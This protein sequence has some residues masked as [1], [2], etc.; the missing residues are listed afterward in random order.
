MRTKY[1]D[2]SHHF[3]RDIVEDKYTVIK[4]IRSKENPEKIITNNCFGW[5][6]QIHEI[7]HRR[8]TMGDCG[9][10]KGEYQE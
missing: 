4:Y 10:W 1:I 5:L 2:I 6:C 3:L 8:R 7:D 9:N